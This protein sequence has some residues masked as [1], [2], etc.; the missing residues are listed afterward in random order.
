MATVDLTGATAKRLV[1]TPLTPG[2]VALID[3]PAGSV[4]G[5][6]QVR[7]VTPFDGAPTVEL[8][9][10]GDTGLVLDTTAVTLTEAKRYTSP[11]L[12]TFTSPATLIVTF[13]AGGATVG[14]ATLSVLI[15]R[16]N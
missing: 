9:I 5:S 14:S 8:G 12:H 16:E 7:V 10:A 15:T 4:V 3:L 6:A 11:A 1:I 2:T 13:T